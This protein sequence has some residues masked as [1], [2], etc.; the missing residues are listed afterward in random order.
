MIKVQIDISEI[1]N[2]LTQIHNEMHETLN[3]NDNQRRDTVNRIV[4]KIRQLKT[5]LSSDPVST[6]VK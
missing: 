3:M 1:R 6:E 2:E 5:T 4:E